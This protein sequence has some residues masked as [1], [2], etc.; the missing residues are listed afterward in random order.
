MVETH[1]FKTAPLPTVRRLP[2]YLAILRDLHERGTEQVSATYIATEL[3]LESIQVRKDLAHTGIVGKPGVGFTIVDLI[4]KIE[5]FLG[6]DNTTDAFLVGAGSLGTALLGYT[7]FK[8]YGLNIAAAFDAD[9]EKVGQSIHG[10]RV[11]PMEKLGDLTGRMHIHMAILTVPA[12]AAQGV[13]DT[14]VAAGIRAIW[15]FTAVSLKVPP[16]VI[17]QNTEL[18]SELAVLSVMLAE[19]RRKSLHSHPP[20]C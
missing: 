5:A 11:L 12:E 4:E 18:S 3:G 8:R 16:Q 7:G 1:D 15:N 6:W 10:K 17:V 13:A 20:S 9:P 19:A 14:L 2:V